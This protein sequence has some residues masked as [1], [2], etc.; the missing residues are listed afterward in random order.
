[1][2]HGYLPLSMLL[3]ETAVLSS[4][5]FRLIFFSQSSDLNFQFKLTSIKADALKFGTLKV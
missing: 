3:Y 5:V 1:M 4:S 2:Q